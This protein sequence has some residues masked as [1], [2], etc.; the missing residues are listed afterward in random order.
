[1]AS[2]LPEETPEKFYIL[3]GKRFIIS[4]AKEAQEALMD[5]INEVEIEGTDEETLIPKIV[6]RVKILMDTHYGRIKRESK[7]RD[8]AIQLRGQIRRRI[9]E[10]LNRISDMVDS[11]PTSEEAA[12]RARRLNSET[13]ELQRLTL[14]EAALTRH[15]ELNE[16]TERKSNDSFFFGTV[17]FFKKELN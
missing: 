17:T 14:D 1:M 4:D 11:D 10:I 8:K 13:V 6:E 16:G 3:E 7:L 9:T 15:L 12:T 5:A 2:K